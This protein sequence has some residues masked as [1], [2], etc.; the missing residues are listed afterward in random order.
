MRLALA[1]FVPLL[2]CAQQFPDAAELL[3]QRSSA[4]K[5]FYSYQYTEDMSSTPVSMTSTVQAINA[6]RY[7]MVAKAAGM[8]AM[9]IVSDGHWVWIYMP[10]FK[11]YSKMP[12]SA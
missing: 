8:D 12:A 9:T 5:N 4:L 7:R 6:D 11:K 10:L 2:V 3:K 1:A